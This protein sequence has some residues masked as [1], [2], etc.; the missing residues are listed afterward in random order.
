M[1]QQTRVDTVIPY[2]REFLK[3]WPTV[4]ALAKAKPDDV[5]SAWSGLGYY[6]R[7]KLMMDAARAIA[8]EHGGEL[9]QDPDALRRLPGFGRYT[10]GAVASIAFDRPAAAVDGNVA[11]VLAR[12]AGIEGDVTRGE[13]QRRVWALAEALAPGEAP[14]EHTQAL[15]ELGALVCATK[16][17][18]CLLCPVGAACVAR[19]DG[20]IGTIPPP[21][22]KAARKAVELT[23][24]LWCEEGDV[25]LTKQPDDGLFGG[26]W[27][28]PLFEG[29]LNDEQVLEAMESQ[30]DWAARSAAESGRIK[31]VLTHRDLLVR[32]VRVR[33]PKPEL[34]APLRFAR[35]DG[36]ESLGVPS[37]TVKALRRGLAVEDVAGL[38][39]PGRRT[40]RRP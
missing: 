9:P 20:T 33:G 7:A 40:S 38:A 16:S 13:P 12:L 30:L 34:K 6:R 35:L 36:L 19:A 15:I 22:R 28:P 3:R 27:T 24:V 8:D 31:H 18:K 29:D 17:P 25:V 10:A 5:R 11:R 2:Y 1:L 26:L 32:L 14:G 21:R 23:A 39:M 4:V 37:L